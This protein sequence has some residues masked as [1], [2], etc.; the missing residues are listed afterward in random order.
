MSCM[1]RHAAMLVATL[2]LGTAR[3]VAAQPDEGDTAII[4]QEADIA[5][6]EEAV[7]DGADSV[8]VQQQGADDAP[9]VQTL[10][11]GDQKLYVVNHDGTWSMH[12]ENLITGDLVRLWREVGGPHVVAKTV[13]DRPYTLSV[14][15]LPPER[16]FERLLDGFDYTLHYDAAGRLERVRVYSLDP[17]SASTFKTPRLVESLG[18]WREL[19]TAASPASTPPAAP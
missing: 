16:I 14:H 10:G 9:V 18:S 15:K 1:R 6:V 4:P 13:L 8:P 5:A 7:P 12:V 3:V 17:S 2:W 19:E 11:D